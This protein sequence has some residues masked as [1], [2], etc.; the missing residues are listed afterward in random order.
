M[1]PAA[2]ALLVM[3]IA[4][5]AVV[6]LPQVEGAGRPGADTG[7]ADERADPVCVVSACEPRMRGPLDEGSD[8]AYD[9]AWR[10]GSEPIVSRR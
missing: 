5:C 4:A 7:R 2:L 3:T 6:P 8:D 9:R 10:S 1:R